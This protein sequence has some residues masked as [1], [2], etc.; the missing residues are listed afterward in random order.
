VCYMTAS[1]V[2]FT[3]YTG[4]ASYERKV[5]SRN[6]SALCSLSRLGLGTALVR[7]GF[8]TIDTRVCRLICA[9]IGAPT[10]SSMNKGE[11]QETCRTA[12][13][14]PDHICHS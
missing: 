14:S 12:S 8:I 10:R 7:R 9:A 3:H 4:V 11:D 13:V 1:V 5:C 2:V 6:T